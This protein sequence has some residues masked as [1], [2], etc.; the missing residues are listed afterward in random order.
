MRIVIRG[1]CSLA[2][3]VSLIGVCSVE[4]RGST[5][6]WGYQ[7]AVN[8][9]NIADIPVGTPVNM[10]WS[11]DTAQPDVCAGIGTPGQGIYFGQTVTLAIGQLTYVASGIFTN[12]TN[13]SQ[14]CG[15]LLLGG[16]ELRL[17]QWSGPNL[18]GLLLN[19]FFPCCA[20][21]S[22]AGIPAT[23][24][25]SLPSTQPASLFVQGP[26]F[27]AGAF[28]TST[29]QTAPE[30]STIALVGTALLAMLRKRRVYSKRT[31]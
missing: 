10:T 29:V 20:S 13:V 27:I 5:I 23:A 11:F 1:L 15:G 19:P 12:H 6:S 7:G 22:I 24:D 14:G 18:P 8:S 3:S 4:A 9:S 31:R 28:V 30:P 25:G 21:P 2:L 16:T 17:I 26:H